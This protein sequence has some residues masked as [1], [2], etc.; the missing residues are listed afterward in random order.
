MAYKSKII[1]PKGHPSPYA[2]KDFICDTP[3][4]VEKLPKFGIEGTQQLN[5]GED[6]V[7]NEP[8]YYNSSATVVEPYSGYVLAPSNNWKQIF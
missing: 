1:S 4:D 8:V 2:I 7:T 3:D 5:D 6:Y